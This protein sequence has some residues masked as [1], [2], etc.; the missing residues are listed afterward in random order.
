MACGVFLC[1]GR[2]FCQYL[3][4]SAANVFAFISISAPPSITHARI[5]IIRYGNTFSLVCLLTRQHS[6]EAYKTSLAGVGSWLNLLLTDYLRFEAGR[7]V[8][9]GPRVQGPLLVVL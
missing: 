6:L 9:Q 5:W 3:H 4:V 2:H 8:L 7:A 1:P